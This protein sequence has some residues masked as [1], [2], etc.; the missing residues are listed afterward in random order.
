MFSSL[1]C[2]TLLSVLRMLQVKYYIDSVLADFEARSKQ[3]RPLRRQ[4]AW[5]VWLLCRKRP[6]AVRSLPVKVE[7]KTL[8]LPLL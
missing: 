6:E 4:V 5:K 7:L 1:W 8:I 3:V 2:K